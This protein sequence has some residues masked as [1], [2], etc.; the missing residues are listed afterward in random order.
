MESSY[1]NRTMDAPYQSSEASS[2]SM[3]NLYPNRTM[4]TPHQSSEASS[5]SMENS[6]RGV[7]GSNRSGRSS[8]SPQ[9]FSEA[10]YRSS[11]SIGTPHPEADTSR[12]W[13]ANFQDSSSLVSNRQKP[14]PL[15]SEVHK[16]YS[17]SR[18]ESRCQSSA[19][20]H[21]LLEGTS[22]PT[23]QPT[24]TPPLPSPFDENYAAIMESRH[25]MLMVRQRALLTRR[26]HRQKLQQ[27]SQQGFFGR[28]KPQNSD[29]NSPPSNRNYRDP[30]SSAE[31]KER[32]E[33]EAHNSRLETPAALSKEERQLRSPVA[34][35]HGPRR[36]K[37]KNK[38]R[39]P[40]TPVASIFSR[41]RPTFGISPASR[42]KGRSQKQAVINRISAVRAAR[43]RRNHAYGEIN[44]SNNDYESF[45]PEKLSISDPVPA[46]QFYPHDDSN[47]SRTT[48]DDDQSLSTRE[49]NPQEYAAEISVD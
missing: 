38:V 43:L 12:P 10:S 46:Y 14:N 16:D 39:S 8:E 47:D 41:I 26:S 44:S 32:S 36:A 5:R 42:D 21:N 33:H 20:R 15:D 34:N 31:D 4:S 13:I 7:D 6:Y 24:V 3:E 11:R 48:R 9:D 1:P 17:P 19:S 25:K 2:R 40:H 27:N 49:S 22:S 29:A 28:T 23:S 37:E 18:D 30:R 35:T 45:R